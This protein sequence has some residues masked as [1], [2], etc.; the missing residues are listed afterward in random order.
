[1]KPLLE[2]IRQLTEGEAL[3]RMKGGTT[4]LVNRLIDG[5]HIFRGSPVKNVEEQGDKVLVENGQGEK[6]LF[7]RVVIATPTPV[8]E[9]FLKQ[10]QFA[11]DLA[12]L[13][14]FRFEEGDLVIHTDPVVMPP[15]RKD[16]A[17]LSYM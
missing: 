14:K 7:D 15:R 3:L 12:L 2:L 5:M 17:V 10:P 16:W 1:A 8:I 4:A 6:K 9:N 13:R 11:E